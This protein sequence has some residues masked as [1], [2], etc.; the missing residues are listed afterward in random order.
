MIIIIAN[1]TSLLIME[2]NVNEE[3]TCKQQNHSFL[4]KYMPQVLF[5]ALQTTILIWFSLQFVHPCLLLYL[6]CY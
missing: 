4:K 2:L 6:L 3:I 1:Y 5:Q